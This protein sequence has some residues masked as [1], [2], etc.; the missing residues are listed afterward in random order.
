[1]SDVTDIVSGRSKQY[2]S[3]AGN[4]TLIYGAYFFVLP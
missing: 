2:Q 3:A 1:M 4:R